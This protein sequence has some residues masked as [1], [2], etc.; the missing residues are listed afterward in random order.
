M[1]TAVYRRPTPRPAR[2]SRRRWI[3]SF[4][5]PIHFDAA[6]S[7]GYEAALSTYSWS[8]TTTGTNRGLLVFVS[9]FASGTVTG[10]TYNGVAM[11]FV[12]SDANGVSRSEVW[13]LENPAS[14]SNTVAVT[15]SASLTSIASAVSYF[16]VNQVNMVE[17]NAGTNGVAGTPS[18]AVTTVTNLDWVASGLSTANTSTS[19]TN[20]VQRANNSG[21]LG[22]GVVDDLGPITPAASTTMT[23]AAQGA[24]QSWALSVVA[25]A[26][27]GSATTVNATW[28]ATQAQ[29]ASIVRTPGHAASASQGQTGTITRTAGH[30]VAAGQGQSASASKAPAR[31]VAATQAQAGT[32]TRAPGKTAAAAQGQSASATK[33]PGRVLVAIE[34][35]AATITAAPGKNLS[36]TQAQAAAFGKGPARSFLATAAQVASVIRTPGKTLLGLQGQA[37][38]VIRSVAHVFV[39]L[40]PQ[41]GTWT[42][43]TSG[44]WAAA[45]TAVAAIVKAPGRIV[46]ASQAQDANL[47]RSVGRSLSASSGA[48]ATIGKGPGRIVTAV[49]GSTGAVVAAP[50]KIFVAGVETLA[51]W[52]VVAIAAM[53]GIV[54]GRDSTPF[55]ADASDAAGEGST[56]G[57]DAASD[58]V[59]GEDRGVG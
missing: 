10:I 4:L 1:P 8:H 41:S 22:S 44:A 35:G 47:S 43:S 11:T 46:A 21:A 37:A 7:S 3:P 31:T 12:R 13:R 38:S 15:L 25:I 51:E 18:Q 53:H 20:G 55:A 17:A 2:S 39:A 52:V 56:L 42:G 16:G 49:A 40:Q 33:G 28:S 36:A 27:V 57:S 5:G 54:T 14:G 23:W 26:P 24:L 30:A 58:L 45:L 6:S 29:V 19:P 9:I 32:V 48:L 34:T 59:Q 50:G